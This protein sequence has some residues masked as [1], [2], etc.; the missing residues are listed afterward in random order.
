[1]FSNQFQIIRKRII[2]TFWVKNTS[3]Q[4]TEERKKIMKAT[5]DPKI[6]LLTFNCQF[7]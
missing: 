7:T 6:T 3:V 2:T 4:T 5:S 1:M